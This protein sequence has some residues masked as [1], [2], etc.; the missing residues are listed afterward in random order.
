MSYKLLTM[1][2]KLCIHEEKSVFFS[3]YN[4]CCI[5]FLIKNIEIG[6]VIGLII[7]LLAGGLGK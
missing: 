4:W 7:G 5:G 2:L 3:Y 1:N 6:L